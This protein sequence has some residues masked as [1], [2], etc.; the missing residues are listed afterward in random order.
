MDYFVFDRMLETMNQWRK[1]GYQ[2]YPMSSNFSRTTLLNPSSLASV[3]AIMSRYPLVPQEL[4]ELEI[5]ETAGDYENHTFEELIRQFGEYGLRFSMD[6][7]GSGYSNMNMLAELKFHSVKLDRGLIKNI[8]ENNTTRMIVRDLVHICDD[9]GMLCIAEGVETREQVEA[10]LQEGCVCCQGF[11]Y[12][13]PMSLEDF[14]EKYLLP[15]K[16][17]VQK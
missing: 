6:D 9:S 11:Y 10:L 1:E 3:L 4:I 13:R 8:T 17:E 5:T 14:K 12:D 2:L 15:K 7:F 16:K